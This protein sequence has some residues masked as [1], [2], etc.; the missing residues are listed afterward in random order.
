MGR[1]SI[2]SLAPA[3]LQGKFLDASVKLEKEQVAEAQTSQP[4][5]SQNETMPRRKEIQ[6]TCFSLSTGDDL[7]LI[8]TLT[9]FTVVLTFQVG[10]KS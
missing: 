1:C 3:L 5:C 10:I 9:P 2:E 4:V 7:I 8:I 6:K